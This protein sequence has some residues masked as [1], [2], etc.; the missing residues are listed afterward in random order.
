VGPGTDNGAN[1]SGDYSTGPARYTT[2]LD[3]RA[4]NPANWTFSFQVNGTNVSLPKAFGGTGPSISYVGMGAGGADSVTAQNFTVIALSA[5]VAPY[6]VTPPQGGTYYVGQSLTLSS[7]SGGAFPLN[8]QWQ[9]NST[10]I[11]GATASTLTFSNL[12][13]TNTGSY[14]L[15][16]ADTLGSATSAPAALIVSTAPTQVAVASNL[17]L[18]L[19]FDGNYLDSSGRGN[20]ATSV[21]STTQPGIVG[22]A[23]A[24]GNNASA[25][26][27]GYATL[28]S[29]PDLLFSNNVNFTV[30]YWIQYT[31]VPDNNMNN[32]SPLVF[33]AC[34][35]PIIGNGVG[36]TYAPGWVI[37]QGGD[38]C[39]NNPGAFVWTLDDTSLT[40]AAAG[41]AHSEDDGNWHHLAHVFDWGQGYGTTYLDGKQVDATSISGL[42]TVDQPNPI[43]IGQDPTGAYFSAGAGNLS[44]MAIWRR[45]LSGNEVRSIYEA[46][47]SNHVSLASLPL[48]LAASVSGGQ[49]RLTWSV[50]VLQEASNVTGPWTNVPGATTPTY[51]VPVTGAREFY[52]A[53]Q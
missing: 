31:N 12:V 28:G 46:G 37:A 22:G 20:N 39:E 49:L 44:D 5:P 33:P 40:V 16:V 52:R 25:N 13:V 14:R 50:G 23:M 29:P 4:A 1:I 11:P 27:L 19:E 48:P 8:Y 32:S 35:L 18:H 43:T 51:T 15:I 7:V 2:I 10:N 26:D 24:Y 41:P 34:D 42:R 38:P 21:G 53:I 9:L 36:G 17:V 6:F 3:T 47:V 45:A 30:A